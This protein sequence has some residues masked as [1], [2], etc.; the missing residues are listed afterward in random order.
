[1]VLEIDASDVVILSIAAA[2]LVAAVMLEMMRVIIPDVYEWAA[3]HQKVKAEIAEAKKSIEKITLL[4][5]ERAAV[6]DRKNAERFRLKSILSRTE[7]TLAA[8]EKERVE[9]WHDVGEQVI[10]DT[11]YLVRVANRAA[12]DRSQRDFDLAPMIWRYTNTVRIWAPNEKTARARLQAAFTADDGYSSSE[13]VSLGG[14]RGGDA[15]KAEPAAAAPAAIIRPPDNRP[16][17]SRPAGQRR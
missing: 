7:M 8:L 6:R 4:N 11:L 13:M 9:V 16:P 2:T 1:M 17:Q 10:G 15:K 5:R 14:A 12:A 3:D